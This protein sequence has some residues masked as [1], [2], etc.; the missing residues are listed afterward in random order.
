MT[1][2]RI[3]L[4]PFG[5]GT[6]TIRWRKHPG[7]RVTKGEP[8]LDVDFKT[9]AVPLP[10]PCSGTLH[11][12]SV[13]DGTDVHSEK[14][15]GLVEAV[16]EKIAPPEP[17][18]ICATC[19]VVRAPNATQC[20]RCNAAHGASVLTVPR[21]SDVKWVS[22]ECAFKCRSCGFVVPLNHLD[23]DGAVICARCSLEQ[24]FDVR[25][26]QGALAFAHDVADDLPGDADNGK[27][28]GKGKFRVVTT[29][30][31]ATENFLE[32]AASPGH[33]LCE[34]CHTTLAIE[35]AADAPK[36]STAKC[37]TCKTSITHQVPDAALKMTN[38]ALRMVMAAEHRADHLAVRVEEKAGVVAV[39]CPSCGA[40]ID[41]PSDEA[42]FVVCKFCS[43]ASRIPTGLGHKMGGAAPAREP[44]WLAFSGT[45]N[46]RREMMEEAEKKH[47]EKLFRRFH[48]AAEASLARA[49]A[50]R[51][52]EEAHLLKQKKKEGQKE[53][54]QAASAIGGKDAGQAPTRKG[55]PIV[56]YVVIG[57]LLAAGSASVAWELFTPSGAAQPASAPPKRA[58]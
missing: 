29:H 12:I 56:V 40:P 39:H 7:D 19:G 15:V 22:V 51:K 33:P 43:T 8:L 20:A 6:G 53:K 46:A 3:R 25:G 24:A 13:T 26:W 17:L 44:M 41:L 37:A 32:V 52:N 14:V 9:E 48:D 36:R 50:E 42:K 28:K 18:E 34:T 5:H 23:V 57:L 10:A 35:I 38:G 31:I 1:Q 54:T 21:P 45:S 2:T 16:A 4:P 55:V 49:R 30:G 47:N 27:A 11:S 58:R